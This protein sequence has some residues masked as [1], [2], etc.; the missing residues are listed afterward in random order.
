MS[1]SE[2]LTHRSAERP[3]NYHIELSYVCVALSLFDHVQ[4]RGCGRHRRRRYRSPGNISRLRLAVL[5]VVLGRRQAL[6]LQQEVVLV[7][8]VREAILERDNTSLDKRANDRV[9]ILHTVDLAISDRV[10][11]SLALAFTF[12]DVL[13]RSRI[14][15]KYLNGRDTA[16]AVRTG[17]QTLRHDVT[18]RLCKA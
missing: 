5:L 1:R 4:H 6:E 7:G 16:L 17:Y 14:R 3:S 13:T 2:L 18:K 11:Q 8:R 10:E 15:P 9:K 12:L